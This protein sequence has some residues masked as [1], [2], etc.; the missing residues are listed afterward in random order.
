MRPE[1]LKKAVDEARKDIRRYTQAANKYEEL[2]ILIAREIADNLVESQKEI[3][4]SFQ[5]AW[6]PL[7]QG[8]YSVFWDYCL[9]YRI[10]DIYTRAVSNIVD[11]TFAT[12]RFVNNAVFSNL[13]AFKPSIQNTRDNLRVFSRTG[14]NAERTH[15]KY[16][17][18][19]QQLDQ[20][21]SKFQ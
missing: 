2:A 11:N 21:V 3:V 20:L 6:V 17:E 1:H 5:S 8:T 10:T 9:S 15:D 4:N 7:I 18:I 12:T 14:V 16:Q 19:L 13:D